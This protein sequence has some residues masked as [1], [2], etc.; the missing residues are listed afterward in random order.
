[1]NLDF[2]TIILLESADLFIKAVVAVRAEEMFE[3]E[4]EYTSAALKTALALEEWWKGSHSN[5]EILTSFAHVLRVRL[6]ACFPCCWSTLQLKKER[7]WGAYHRFR[8]ADTFVH[9]WRVFL[10][11]SVNMKAFP[12]FY[13]FV[14]HAMFKE[15]IKAHYPVLNNTDVADETPSRPLTHVEQNALRYVAGYVTRKLRERLETTSHPNRD[16]MVLLLMECA[17]DELDEDGGTE[18]WLNMI[19]RGGLWHVNDQ[20]YSLFNIMEDEIRRFF[21]L[22][23]NRLKGTMKAAAVEAIL[24]SEDL[25]F[26]W[27]IIAAEADDNVATT[28]LH[29]IVELY[30]TIRGFA[31]AKSCLEMYKQ[32]HKKTLQKKR[33]LRSEL[34]PKQ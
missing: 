24:K 10:T 26:E 4:T 30:V 19:D 13:Q 17:G 32:A 1:M 2:F 8:T 7:M 25:L 15:L 3:V 5:R 14:T 16:E 34:C 21:T 29:Q 31:F 18:T 20:T 22:S 28:V 6:D 33:A 9:D 12:V 23:A 11:K 27:C